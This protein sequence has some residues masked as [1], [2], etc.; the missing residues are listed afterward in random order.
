[1]DNFMAL[2]LFGDIDEVKI[3]KLQK[4]AR[5]MNFGLPITLFLRTEKIL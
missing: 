3:D 2:L 5:I 4:D 1:M